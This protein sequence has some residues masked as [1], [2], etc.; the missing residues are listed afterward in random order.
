MFKAY[1]SIVFFATDLM[2]LSDKRARGSNFL[3]PKIVKEKL[4]AIFNTVSMPIVVC[5]LRT[6]AHQ[7]WLSLENRFKT[8]RANIISHGIKF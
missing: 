2:R 4:K 6:C 3:C 8:R 7:L 5:S 1:I